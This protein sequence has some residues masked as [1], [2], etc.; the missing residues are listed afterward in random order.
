MKLCKKCNTEKE[1]LMFTKCQD[2]KDGYYHMC[3]ECRYGYIP[4]QKPTDKK[5]CNMCKEE[6]QIDL[7][8]FNNRKMNWRGPNCRK[9]SNR[10]RHLRRM[11]NTKKEYLRSKRRE[12]KWKYGITLEEYDIMY[13]KQDKKCKICKTEYPTL[14][15][16]H[17]HITNKVRGLLCRDCNLGLG[18][19]KDN[20]E[21]L[22]SAIKYLK[23]TKTDKSTPSWILID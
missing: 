15:I 1:F 21:F 8:P 22:K 13:Y 17:C 16:D 12:I 10:G 19:Y 20:S 7:F 23:E 18:H 2:S 3:K 9:C 14:A 5:V 4:H 11:E 6:K